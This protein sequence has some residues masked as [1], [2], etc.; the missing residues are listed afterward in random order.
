MARWS[1][2]W[3]LAALLGGGSWM[4]PPV[5][6]QEGAGPGAV[7]KH[8][9]GVFC[10]SEDMAKYL[11]PFERA[12]AEARASFLEL[13]D[14]TTDL[15]KRVTSIDNLYH[16]GKLSRDDWATQRQPLIEENA[17]LDPELDRRR[18]RFNGADE[19]YET[20]VRYSNVVDCR[21]RPAQPP[22]SFEPQPPSDSDES[23]REP[24]QEIGA[25]PGGYRPPGGES[26][27][28][29]H[30]VDQPLNVRVPPPAKPG[31]DDGQDEPASA[32]QQP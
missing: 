32:P 19:A 21:A 2:V 29:N 30:A 18:A 14:H 25:A 24:R 31:K 1:S 17:G 7:Y 10:T 9:G 27:L 16:D 22:S 15:V 26:M 28:T 4:T 23:E 5:L 12:R 8:P 6:A 20:A 11:A 13:L 3:V